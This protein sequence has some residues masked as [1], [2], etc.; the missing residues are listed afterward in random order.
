MSETISPI[1]CE[2]LRVSMRAAALGVKSS[3]RIAARTRSRNSSDTNRVLLTTCETVLVDTPARRATSWTVA[4][5]VITLLDGAEGQ[6]A[7]QLPLR[8]PADEHDR[9]HSHGSSSSQLGPEQALRRH[10]ADHEH[11]HRGGAGRGQ[12][13]GEKE[14]VP[15]EDHTDEHGRREPRRNHRQDAAGH[16]VQYTAPVNL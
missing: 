3:S 12:A 14:L 15:G 8:A 13:D 2:R 1:V 16:L 6:T 10:E 11:R 4:I 7:H 5:G 9:Q